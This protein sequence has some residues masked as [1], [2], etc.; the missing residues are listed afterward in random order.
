MKVTTLAVKSKP[1]FTMEMQAMPLYGN[2][3]WVDV[4]PGAFSDAPGVHLSDVPGH[5]AR[6]V[7][8]LHAWAEA[9]VERHGR[10]TRLEVCTSA[11]VIRVE[12]R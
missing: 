12:P 4:A 11:G 2:D 6:L 7:E 8:A 10:L 9:E 3:E 5:T 1:A